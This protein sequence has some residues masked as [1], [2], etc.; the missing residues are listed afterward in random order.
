[1][2]D[3]V[4]TLRNVLYLPAWPAACTAHPRLGKEIPHNDRNVGTHRHRRWEGIYRSE[5]HTSELQS[6]YVISYAVFC[7]KKKIHT[8]HHKQNVI[9][10]ATHEAHHKTDPH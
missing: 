1:M 8:L 5:E 2:H 10:I 6:P 9:L 3:L 4:D 7:L